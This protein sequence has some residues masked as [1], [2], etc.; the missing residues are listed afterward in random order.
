MLEL[1]KFRNYLSFK[2]QSV[3]DLRASA[4]KQH[5]THVFQRENEF[6]DS[7]Y[8]ILKTVAIYGANAS[9]KS[10]VIAALYSMKMFILSQL[11]QKTDS[12][13]MKNSSFYVIEPFRLSSEDNSIEFEIVFSNLGSRIQ[14]GFELKKS[15]SDDSEF[16]DENSNFIILSEWYDI[17]GDNVFER[18]GTE[19]KLGTKYQKALREYNK[20]PS[21]RLY[22]SVL[23]YFLEDSIKNEIIGAFIDFF[24]NKFNVFAD[25]FLD[26]PVK[27]MGSFAVLSGRLFSD[28]DFRKKVVQYLRQIDVGIADLVVVEDQLQDGS[29]TKKRKRIKTVHKLFDKKGNEAGNIEFDLSQ[30]STGTLRFLNYIQRIIEI[31]ENSG[32][33]VV[34]ELSSKLHPLITKFIIDMF[35]SSDNNNSQLVFSTHDIFHLSKEQFR[36]DE[37]VFINKNEYGESTLYSLADLKIREDST[38]SKDY[39]LGKYGAIPIFKD[40]LD[41][42]E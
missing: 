34:D 35:Q 26:V 4:Y 18:N 27:K 6:P 21:D 38:F 29:M 2:N 8:G 25:V 15:E 10:N 22:I 7:K 20:L 14:Y 19:I 41:E 1:F 11:Y 28:E 31:Q 39:I 23:D 36:R 37:V 33:F 40:M 5:S 16:P 30:E 9:G 42:E 32:V 3:L 12:D 24:K 13:R 17:D